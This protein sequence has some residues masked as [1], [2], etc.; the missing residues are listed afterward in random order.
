MEP[1]QWLSLGL[2]RDAQPVFESG[3]L[4]TSEAAGNAVVG[5]PRRGAGHRLLGTTGFREEAVV[6]AT[7]LRLLNPN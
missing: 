2:A 3:W 7:I 5:I 1:A 4:R 6:I